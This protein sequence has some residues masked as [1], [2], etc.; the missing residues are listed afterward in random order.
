MPNAPILCAC[1]HALTR[2]PLDGDGIPQACTAC[3]DCPDFSPYWL[4]GPPATPLEEL[5]LLA[6]DPDD[7]GLVWGQTGRW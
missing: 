6:A 7:D 3:D 2:H 5:A 1:A 4:G